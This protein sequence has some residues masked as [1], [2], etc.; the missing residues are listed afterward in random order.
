[1]RNQKLVLM[2]TVLIPMILA[3]GTFVIQYCDNADEIKR[4]SEFFNVLIIICSSLAAYFA[5]R[6][7]IENNQ[8]DWTRNRET[9]EKLK[10]E[11]A[12]F[13]GKCGLYKDYKTEEERQ[14]LFRERIEL[15]VERNVSRFSSLNIDTEKIKEDTLS[16][17]EEYRKAF[18]TFK[19]PT[20]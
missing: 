1:M 6:D 19:P 12:M 13:E 8:D 16:Q 4:C 9:C 3:G 18:P 20:K 7:K 10:Q 15:L 17:L 11:F 2:L 14:R 5:S